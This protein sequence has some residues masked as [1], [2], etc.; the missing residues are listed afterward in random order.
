MLLFNKTG[1]QLKEV[2][3]EL[4]RLKEEH[5]KLV[6]ESTKL[7]KEAQL[8]MELL[9]SDN[10]K[11]RSKYGALI[12]ADAALAEKRNAIHVSE[13]ALQK[14]SITYQQALQEQENAYVY[15]QS[16]NKQ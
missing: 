15:K 1:K 16:N 14:L 6:Q 8:E 11:L 5:N 10:N 9:K 2:Q 3:E 12:D 7:L 13:A 4:D